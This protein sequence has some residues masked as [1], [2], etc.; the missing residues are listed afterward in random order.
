IVE[1]M[2][3]GCTEYLTRP[4][5]VGQFGEALDR[6]HVRLNSRRITP[7]RAA[8]RIIAI[9]GVRG[10]AGATTLAVHLG[11]F[12][13]GQYGKK[14]LIVDERSRLGHVSLYMGKDGANYHFYELVRNISRLDE[15]LLQGFVVHHSELLDILPSPDSFDDSANVALEDVQRALRFLGQNY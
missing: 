6:L 15:S 9:L 13:S 8:G 3:A 10:G 2:R 4:V 14:T 1:A 11:C 7:Q 5:S 12:L